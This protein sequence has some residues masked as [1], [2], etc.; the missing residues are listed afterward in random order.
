MH[1]TAPPPVREWGPARI[2]PA[3][4]RGAKTKPIFPY[5]LLTPFLCLTYVLLYN[6]AFI[7]QKALLCETAYGGVTEVRRESGPSHGYARRTVAVCPKC[8]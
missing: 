5:P 3:M 2:P 1:P 4:A 8:L 6:T 7:A